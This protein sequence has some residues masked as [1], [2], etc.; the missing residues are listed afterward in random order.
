MLKAV[1]KATILK[2]TCVLVS[3]TLVIASCIY[4]VNAPKCVL[5]ISFLTFSAF[6]VLIPWLDTQRHETLIKILIVALFSLSAIFVGY[7][8]L[9][10]TGILER[11][12][13]V[14]GMISL[15]RSLGSLGVVIFILFIIINVVFLPIP[16][17]V[18]AII[19]TTLYGPLW[20][21][22]YMAIGTTIGSVITFS[23]GKIFGKR[24]A[25]W[26]VGKE[27]TEKYAR[28]LNEKGRLAFIFMIIFPFFPDDILCL[29]AGISHMSYRYFIFVICTIRTATLAFMC[30]FSNGKIIPFH[31]WGLV[32]WITIGV[33][34]I[35][36][37]IL[38]AIL[39]KRIMH[40]QKSPERG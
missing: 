2:L 24:V 6:G 14:D 40:Q 32:V 12:G 35:A 34:L 37:F 38:T 15:I 4:L 3:L 31:G 23:L 11:A 7:I 33:A 8:I 39:K 26:M 30:F 27:K 9:E 17:A 20:S 36:A 5:I 16:A 18:P 13:N 28:F 25:E 19:G 22:V 10:L 29:I 21:F 1:K